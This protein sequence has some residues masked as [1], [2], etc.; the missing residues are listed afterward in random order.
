MGARTRMKEG[1]AA[2][3]RLTGVTAI[4]RARRRTSAVVLTYHGVLPSGRPHDPYLSR[5]CVDDEIFRAQMAFLTRH[6]T[7]L[8]LSEIVDRLS[9]AAP[10][11]P[12]AAAVTFD[13]GFRNNYQYAFPAL[14]ATGVPATIFVATG[15]IGRECLMLWTERVAW[16]LQVAPADLREVPVGASVVAVD[17]STTA[18]RRESSRRLLK[19]LKGTDAAIR[20]AAVAWLDAAARN[21]GAPAP[22]PDRYAFMTWDEARAMAESGLVEIGSH[23]VTHL[24]LAT[25]TPERRREELQASKQDVEHH[26][27]RPCRLFAYPNGT[28]ADFD[29]G[30]QRLLRDLGYAGAVSQVPG[31]NT[32]ATDLYALRRYN[33]SRG[34]SL[35]TIAGMLAGV[36]PAGRA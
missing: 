4:G 15:H 33:V 1:L 16:L 17:L 30:D 8:P 13:D 36:W 18:A 34:H 23:T 31:V 5:N 25:A 35:D 29:A 27:E 21:G 20:D 12:R 2:A 11:P 9:S 32:A 22:D 6:Y 3:L 26:L 7:C 28:R 19:H 10:L 24:L 14:K